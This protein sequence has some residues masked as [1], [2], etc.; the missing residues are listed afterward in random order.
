MQELL[1]AGAHF[2]HKVSRG[3]PRM[4]RYVYGARDGVQ[5]ID[6]AKTEQLLKEAVQAVYELG[7]SGA[8]LLVIG[9]KKQAQ[10]ITKELAES[11]DTPYLN[12]KWTPGLFTNFDELK[13]NIKKLNELEVKKQKGEL[14][15]YT[16]KEQLLI[17]K[18]LEKFNAVMGGISAM[19]KLPDAI[20]VIDSVADKISVKEANAS[21]IKVFGICD[22]NADPTV[23]DYPVPAN[24][25]GIK[26]IKIISEAVLGAY[27][28]GKKEGGHKIGEVKQEVKENKESK[29]ADGETKEEIVL[30]EAVAEEAAAIEEEIEKVVVEE[31]ARKVA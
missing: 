24:D 5:I 11:A 31:S 25:D 29:V 3:N 26:S 19:D 8:V 17:S 15:L 16:K 2:G 14:S 30:S 21:G 20:F 28:Q 1:E 9:T 4:G 13:R 6:L 18:K 23:F 7:K 12:L 10:Q 22:S 27:A